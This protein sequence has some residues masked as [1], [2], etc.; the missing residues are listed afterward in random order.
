MTLK[1]LISND[2]VFNIF[3][4]ANIPFLRLSLIAAVCSGLRGGLPRPSPR[5][6]GGVWV[7]AE[8]GDRLDHRS[9]PSCDIAVTTRLL[10]TT[11][12][13]SR[14]TANLVPRGITTL[15]HSGVGNTLGP[16]DWY[17]FLSIKSVLTI[18]SGQELNKQEYIHL[19][20]VPINQPRL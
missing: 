3:L 12:R 8:G 7:H 2:P 5:P 15:L 10:E 17:Y 19:S 13:S 18:S 20:C 4:D 6:P 16:I 14:E 11:C 9:H 1:A